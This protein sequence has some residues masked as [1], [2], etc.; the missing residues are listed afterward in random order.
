[1]LVGD[2]RTK[3]NC[4]CLELMYVYGGRGGSGRVFPHHTAVGRRLQAELP[5][6]GCTVDAVTTSTDAVSHLIPVQEVA[7]PVMVMMV[8]MLVMVASSARPPEVVGVRRRTARPGAELPAL[9]RRRPVARGLAVVHCRVATTAS[10]AARAA[11][12]VGGQFPAAHPH[13]PREEQLEEEPLELLAENHVDDE[14]DGRVDRHQQIAD[15]DQVID[16]D[17]VEC[18]YHVRYERPHVAQQEHHYDAQQHGGQSDLLLLQPRKPLSLSVSPPHLQHRSRSISYYSIT[19]I[20]FDWWVRLGL[21]SRYV[22]TYSFWHIQLKC[23]RGNFS[24]D[25]P[26]KKKL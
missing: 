16:D 18:L 21:W 3:V 26:K 9:E 5:I 23:V 4:H 14:V 22:V 8:V 24:R 19:S 7:V 13:A 6:V 1:M 11:P 12:A 2:L 20:L 17:A 15:F 10:L 25:F